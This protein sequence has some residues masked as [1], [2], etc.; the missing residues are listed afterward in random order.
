[1]R[2]FTI[3]TTPGN[4]CRVPDFRSHLAEGT[5]VYITSLPGSDFS[6]TVETCR[7]LTDQGMTPV[8]HLAAR[9]IADSGELDERLKR[10]TS[11]AGVTRVLTIAGSDREAA[12]SFTDTLSMLETG[13]FEKYEIRSIGV[14]GHPEHAPGL[15]RARLQEHEA[16]KLEFARKS[17]I[18]MYMLTQFVFD[19][20]PV[21]DFVERIRSQGNELPVVVGLPGLA[22][23]QS[24]LRYAK[25]CGIGPST[26]FLMRRARDLHKLLSVQAPDKLV[27]DIA[28]YRAANADCGITGAHLYPF[29]A[30]EKSATW[31]NAVVAGKFKL[32]RSGFMVADRHASTDR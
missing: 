1:M 17:G 28:S 4:A 20:R 14:A 7:K 11:E 5:W 8:P 3:E 2:P 30:F 27:L 12:G 31:A 21:I 6:G 13:L 10:M 9:G 25:A 15:D 22:T 16:R 18:E 26:Q 24:L 23:V 19:A 32:N 29:G